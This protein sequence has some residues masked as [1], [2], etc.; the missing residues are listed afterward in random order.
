MGLQHYRGDTEAALGLQAMYVST[1]GLSVQHADST[2]LLGKQSV[3]RGVTSLEF[4]LC[5]LFLARWSQALEM[6]PR[7]LDLTLDSFTIGLGAYWDH[8]RD[9]GRLRRGMSVST[10]V[11]FPLFGSA[12]GPWLNSTLALRFAEGPAFSAQADVMVGLG[13]TWA[14]LIDSGLHDDNP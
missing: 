7:L 2:F 10:G 9:I 5:P 4:R 8:D 13:L 6:G 11:S 1:L 14:L 12:N 3:N